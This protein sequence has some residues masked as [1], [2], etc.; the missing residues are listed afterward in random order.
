MH[1]D[2]VR[3]HFEAEAFDYDGLIPRLIPHYHEQHG[4][5]L[6][7]IPF[8]RDASLKVLD[9]GAGTGVLS[10]LILQAFPNSTVVAFDIAENMLAACKKNLS[11]YQ[12]RVKLH[13]GNFAE[14][15]VGS[16]YDLV[17]SGLAIHHLDEPEKQKLYQ[18]LFH[19]VN[20]GGLLLIRD[21]VTGATPQ[22]TQQ[23][24]RLWRHYMK[25]NGED[26]EKWFQNY[27]KED[28]PSSVED[29]LQWLKSAGFEEVGC[30]WRYLNFAIFGGRKR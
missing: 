7:L 24:E 17:I 1:L 15:D 13:Q 23:Y 5:M 21:T 8:E 20:P 28:R 12:E 30:H 9:L 29:Q 3:A 26:D 16:E 2:V 27:L 11:A 19:A 10:C 25:A 14:D 4:L 18:D 6:E 22:L